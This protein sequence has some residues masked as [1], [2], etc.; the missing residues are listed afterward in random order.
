[1]DI[2]NLTTTEQINRTMTPVVIDLTRDPGEMYQL[3]TYTA[4]Y[5]TEV[6]KMYKV[7]ADHLTNLVKGRPALDWCDRAV[8]VRR[9]N[10]AGVL[11]V[12]EGRDK[13][14]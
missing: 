7:T 1:M 2:A 5:R 13:K 10:T 9:G 6:S 11:R 12:N 3:P 8:M 4:E 14:E